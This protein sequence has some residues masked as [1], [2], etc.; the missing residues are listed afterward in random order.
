MA[1]LFRQLY[2][3][4]CVCI[5]LANA[6]FIPSATAC[7]IPVFRYALDNWRP[8]NFRL[9]LPAT[10]LNQPG[11]VTMLRPL[12]SGSG[13][14]IEIKPAEGATEAR[15]LWPGEASAPVWSGELNAA[16]VQ[17]FASSTTSGE[18]VRRILDGHSVVWVLVESADKEANEAAARLLEK[19]LRY[20]EQVAELPVMDPTDPS[21]K[22]GP[23]PEL[24]VKFSLVRVS[25]APVS[26]P[27]RASVSVQ[28]AGSEIGAPGLE[29]VFLKTLAGP[30]PDAALAN[31]P[32]LAAVFGRGRVLGAWPA[33]GFGDEQIDEVCL[34]LLGACSCRVKNLNP[35]WDLLLASDWDEALK[36]AGQNVAA[37]VASSSQGASS[38]K[39]D[40][41]KPET[42]R[43]EPATPVIAVPAAPVAVTAPESSRTKAGLIA[44]FLV[45]AGVALF[46][47]A[48]RK[49]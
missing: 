14:N 40:E 23:G 42:T 27:A 35:G 29:S 48:G 5:L 9:E 3:I 31:G 47:A 2:R 33:K 28:N 15:L 8:D 44:L 18:I 4:T 37:K 22:L 21:N 32:W 7:S 19:R 43:I 34:F 12:G 13:M 24:K 46:F 20:L 17:S 1:S 36:A 39:A 6:I 25:G 16:T 11:A 49:S 10:F 38:L 26:D 41:P 45:G 30:K